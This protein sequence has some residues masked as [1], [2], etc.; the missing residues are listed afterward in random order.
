MRR[1]ARGSAVKRATVSKGH[2]RDYATRSQACW[3]LQGFSTMTVKCPVPEEDLASESSSRDTWLGRFL[4]TWARVWSGSSRSVTRADCTG[5]TV[6]R[7]FGVSTVTIKPLIA[8]CLRVLT[9]DGLRTQRQRWPRRLSRTA[10]SR[11]LRRLR[12]VAES[13]SFGPIY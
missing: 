9:E 5:R 12:P 6:A 4:T 13:V 10:R 3:A 1:V 11:E 2:L 7:K 8:H